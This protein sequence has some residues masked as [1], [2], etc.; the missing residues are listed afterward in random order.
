MTK[1]LEHLKAL[2][3]PLQNG[4]VS[5]INYGMKLMD[6]RALFQTKLDSLE[7]KQQQSN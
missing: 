3:I 2:E 6:E 1:D 4:L 7:T 5:L